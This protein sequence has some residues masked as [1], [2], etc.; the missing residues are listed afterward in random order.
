M[1]KGGSGILG[2]VIFIGIILLL[3]GLSYL[4]SWGWIFY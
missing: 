2:F 3:N 4:F 1:G